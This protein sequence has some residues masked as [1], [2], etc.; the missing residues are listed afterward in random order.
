M[1]EKNIEEYHRFS[2][3]PPKYEQSEAQ[4]GASSY[5]M[6][7]PTHPL[8]PNQPAVYVPPVNVY[9]T[10]Q[11]PTVVYINA[12]VLNDRPVRTTCPNCRA[13]ILTQLKYDSGL[14]AW[15]IAAGLCFFGLGC[16]CCLIPFCVDACK[17]VEHY[18]PNCRTL[19]GRYKRI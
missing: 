1:A 12:P 9:Q 17:D 15:L 7:Q 5:Q 11:Q 14:A 3:E 16:G 18:C 2:E 10:A 4:Q 8:Y 6:P 19:I 13:N